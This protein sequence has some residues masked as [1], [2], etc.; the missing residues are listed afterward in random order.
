MRMG[1][2]RAH[3]VR[4]VALSHVCASAGV[5]VM[6]AAHPARALVGCALLQGKH[7]VD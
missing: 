3:G 6:S 4:G 7:A 5:M 1:K 2:K